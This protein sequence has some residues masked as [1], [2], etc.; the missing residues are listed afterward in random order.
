MQVSL[1]GK[2]INLR[3]ALRERTA[4]EHARLDAAAAPA[5]R[6]TGSYALF[7]ARQLAAREPIEAWV[8]EN[9]PA[10]IAPPAT[11]PLLRADLAAL[12]QAAGAPGGAFQLPAE[13]DPVGLAWALAGSHLGNRAMLKTVRANLPGAPTAFLDDPRMTEFWRV[14]RPR[15]EIAASPAQADSAA[16]AA[17]A[18]FAR[19][20]AIFAG[21]DG[22]LAA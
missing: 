14:L 4:G 11:V 15:L 2:I 22:R 9:C 18:V 10:D 20:L 1:E 17:Q 3:G 19:F 6:D 12:G 13:A 8:A 21:A 16:L 7:L 5:L